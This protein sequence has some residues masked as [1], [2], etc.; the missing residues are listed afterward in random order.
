MTASVYPI[1]CA[2]FIPKKTFV[3]ASSWLDDSSMTG[4]HCV[5]TPITFNLKT[6]FLVV[7]YIVSVL[8][9]W[10]C[11]GCV[12]QSP[13]RKSITSY[14][15]TSTE[16]YFLNCFGNFWSLPEAVTLIEPLVARQFLSRDLIEASQYWSV[17]KNIFEEGLLVIQVSIKFHRQPNISKPLGSCWTIYI[18]SKTLVQFCCTESTKLIFSSRAFFNFYFTDLKI[19][20]SGVIRDQAM[21]QREYWS[22]P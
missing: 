16:R 17:V 7:K 9:S 3:S 13:N 10:W 15:L 5:S 11:F 21:G 20:P 8:I 19:F 2:N 14:L 1:S 22:N 4:W 6:S 12:F 18:P